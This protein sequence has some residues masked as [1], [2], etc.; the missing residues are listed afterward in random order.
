MKPKE[1]KS[2][3]DQDAIIEVIRHIK[4]DQLYVLAWLGLVVINLQLS[5]GDGAL[6]PSHSDMYAYS[7]CKLRGGDRPRSLLNSD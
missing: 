5:A 6:S 3:S 7:T 4:M 1:H 2:P